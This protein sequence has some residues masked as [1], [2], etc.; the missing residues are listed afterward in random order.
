MKL[1]LNKC[2]HCAAPQL[3]KSQEVV[4]IK[5][6]PK[7]GGNGTDFWVECGCC[8]TRSG[9]WDT[10]HKAQY[11]WNRRNKEYDSSELA[12]CGFL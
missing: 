4:L 5:S 3:Y 7:V 12:E 1:K 10:E 8:R 2:P 9:K 11:H 6:E